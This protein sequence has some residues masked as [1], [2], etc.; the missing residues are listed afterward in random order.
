M[1]NLGSG[2]PPERVPSTPGNLDISREDIGRA[3]RHELGGGTDTVVYATELDGRSQHIPL[4]VKIADPNGTMDATQ[5]DRIVEEATTWEQLTADDESRSGEIERRGHIVDIVDW[6]KEPLPWLALEYMD[7]GSLRDVLNEGDGQLPLNQAL[8]VGARVCEGVLHAHRHGV[9]HRDLKP[10]NIL[11]RKPSRGWLFPKVGDWGLARVMLETDTRRGLTP[12]YAAPEQFHHNQYGRPGP[13]TDIYQIGVLVYELVTGALPFDGTAP[14]ISEAKT[15]EEPTPPSEVADVPP[16]VDDVLGPALKAEKSARYE[17][18]VYLRDEL[19]ALFEHRH[20]EAPGAGSTVRGGSGATSARDH[21]DSSGGV[22]TAVERD[23]SGSA[24][25]A[26]SEDPPQADE[27]NESLG[28]PPENDDR[29]GDSPAMGSW[30]E[31][32]EELERRQRRFLYSVLP[33]SLR[34]LFY[35]ELVTEIDRAERRRDEVK[36]DIEERK[37]TARELVRQID[38]ERL[39]VGG[40]SELSQETLERVGEVEDTRARLDTLL[41]KHRTYL[42]TDEQETTTRLRDQLADCEG[43]LHT[44]PRLD[45]RVRRVGE[46]LDDIE[47]RIDETLTE[48]ELLAAEQKRELVSHLDAVSQSLSTCRRRLDMDAVTTQ[49]RAQFD[50]L[51]KREG[52]LRDRIEQHNPDL[53]QQRYSDRID[54]A[55]AVRERTDAAIEAYRGDGTECPEQ[56]ATYLEQLDEQLDALAA[57]LDSRQ[58]E[59]LSPDQ[60]DRIKRLHDD[61]A[62]NRTLFEARAEFEARLPELRDE[63][64]AVAATVAET[65]D[66]ETYL[67]ASERERLDERLDEIRSRLDSLRGRDGFDRLTEAD[68]TRLTAH[69]EQLDD[70][71]AE[72]GEYNPT[73]VGQHYERHR[74]AVVRIQ[75]H[76]RETVDDY[77]QD[78]EALPEPAEVYTIRLDRAVQALTVFLDRPQAGHLSEDQREHVVQFRTDLRE[79]QAYVER[80]VEFDARLDEIRSAI[81]SLRSTADDR[82]D[83]ETY[84]SS[85]E[86]ERLND[87]LDDIRNRLGGLQESAGFDRLTEP[88]Q[89]ET[90]ACRTAVNDLET[91]IERYNPALVQQRYERHTQAAIHLR[92]ETREALEPCREDG[93]PLPELAGVYTS[94]LDR[95]VQALTAFLDRPQAKHL[96]EDQREHVVQLRTDLEEGRAYVEGKAEFDRLLEESRTALEDLETAAAD[97]LDMETYLTTPQRTGLQEQIERVRGLLDEVEDEELRETVSAADIERFKKCRSAVGDI[98]T[99]IETYNEQFVEHECEALDQFGPADQSLNER[100][101]RAVVRDEQHNRVIAGPGTGKTFSLLARIAYLV[102]RDVPPEEILVLSYGRLSREELDDRLSDQFDVSDIEVRTLHSYGKSVVDRVSPDTVWLLGETRLREVD[103]LLGDLRETDADVARHYDEFLDLYRADSFS[104][105]QEDWNNLY[106]SLKFNKTKTLQGEEVDPGDRESRTA[107][108]T[109]ADTLFEYGV[110]YQ[111]RKYAPWAEPADGDPYIPDFTLPDHNVCIEYIPSKD[112]NSKRKWYDRKRSARPIEQFYDGTD[113]TVLTIHGADIST[114]N[115]DRILRFKLEDAGV[116]IGHPLG[117]DALIQ[118]SYEYNTLRRTVVKQVSKFIKRAKTNQMEPASTLEELDEEE[119]PIV[120]H[121]SH[122]ATAVLEAYRRQY[123]EYGAHDYADMVLGATEVFEHGHADDSMAFQHVLVDEFQD[124]NL[125]RIEFLKAILK[126]SGEAH[127]FGVGDDWQSIYGYQGARPEFF[128]DFEERFAP[129]TTTELQLN[130][131]CP[132]SVVEASNA[133]MTGSDIE[134]TKS[135]E[136]AS[137]NPDRTPTVHIVPGGGGEDAFEYN[138]NVVTNV[139]ELVRNSIE[140]EHRAPGEIL[141]LARNEE[142]SPFIRDISKALQE[143][144]IPTKGYNSV[145]VTTAHKAK[146]SEAEHVI[147]VNAVQGKSD[148]FPP[149]ERTESLIQLVDAGEESHIAEERRL[150]YMALT[151]VKERLDIQTRANFQS[152]FLDPLGGYV[153]YE[154]V[155]IDCARDHVSVTGTVN[156]EYRQSA[157]KRQVGTLEVDGYLLSYAIPNGA[158]DTP[159]L[160]V[161]QTYRIENAEIGEYNGNPQLRI[162]DDATV[163]RTADSADQMTR[164]VETAAVTHGTTRTDGEHASD[165]TDQTPDADDSQNSVQCPVEDCD[166]TEKPSSVAAH[167]TGKRDEE[168]DWSTLP[169]ASASEFKRTHQ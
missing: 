127:L 12:A 56:L 159:L 65:L 105:Y 1:S 163:E 110:D 151:R 150:F 23:S 3:D 72:V 118:K 22:G 130:Y 39:D 155:P 148:G 13:E 109:I 126:H 8:W 152:P 67:S 120:Y 90:E 99:H 141:I 44:K 14:E 21:T 33:G 28:K 30:D 119:D 100:Q 6:G 117:K 78:A 91:E 34:R 145:D 144:D 9:V 55:T 167:I 37:D 16:A 82:L 121:F 15:S 5:F 11:F 58:T 131:R 93:A 77:R 45:R 96:S 59:F 112:A 161:E 140:R 98:E 60:A 66:W 136:A 107:V 79:E 83:M 165:G 146:G 128:V 26:D 85:T 153:E 41:E 50:R 122:V 40:F 134:T 168:H 86:R 70:L 162:D 113:R 147:I 32:R 4:A 135:L 73:L 164:S 54:A 49:D 104:N 20:A 125:G 95:V 157:R 10:S 142:G 76:I 51:V 47:E 35:N 53:V 115:I 103:E 158:V 69:H 156:S 149:V 71:E 62:A 7:G 31:Y 111:Y 114:G 133:L 88:E 19:D 84:L 124:L 92:A 81:G 123:D 57:F 61:L 116:S 64:D 139:V 75:A 87:R 18:I 132:P 143:H 36:A 38:Q 97:H 52:D 101:R 154:H 106:N 160:Q 108:T 166:Y 42:T 138:P 137:S 169:Y 24:A 80:K 48:S 2:G 27:D 102:E 68:R 74:E 63:V 129:A 43:Y 94:P 25:D 17:D 29:D 46:E 89:T